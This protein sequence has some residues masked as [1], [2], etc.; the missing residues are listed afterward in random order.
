[1]EDTLSRNKSRI[2]M[3]YRILENTLMKIINY[4]WRRFYK[5]STTKDL[6]VN[7]TL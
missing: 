4:L 5:S 6:N 1:M 3:L 7:M 2:L